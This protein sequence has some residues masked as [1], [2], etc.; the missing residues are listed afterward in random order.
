MGC[1]GWCEWQEGTCEKGEGP[2][3]EKRQERHESSLETIVNWLDWVQNKG[4]NLPTYL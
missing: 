3:S 4:R 1:L 2:W